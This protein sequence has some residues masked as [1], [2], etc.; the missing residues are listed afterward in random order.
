[1]VEQDEGGEETSQSWRGRNAA[2]GPQS[3]VKGFTDKSLPWGLLWRGRL[4]G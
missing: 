4:E 3:P 1:M 2:P